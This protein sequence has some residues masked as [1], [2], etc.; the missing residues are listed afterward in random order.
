VKHLQAL[1]NQVELLRTKAAVYQNELN[2]AHRVKE[3]DA[4]IK[5]LDGMILRLMTLEQTINVLNAK[6]A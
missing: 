3:L 2:D 6:I 5:K 4:E 1:K